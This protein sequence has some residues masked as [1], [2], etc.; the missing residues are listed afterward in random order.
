M[1]LLDNFASTAGAAANLTPIGAVLN[2]GKTLIDRFVPDPALAAQA[3]M[4]LAHMASDKAMAE[5]NASTQL[6]LAQAGTNS[7]EAASNRLFV[8][9]W[10]PAVGWCC[11]AALGFKYVGGP[12]LAMLCQAIGYQVQMPQVDASEILPLLLGMLGLGAMRTIEKVK[13]AA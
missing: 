5:L 4:E 11:V 2:I 3:Q 10:R 1:G 7:I 6:A 12:L 13:G 8:A 9:G